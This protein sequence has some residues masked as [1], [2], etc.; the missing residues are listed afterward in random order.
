M[1]FISDGPFP[2]KHNQQFNNIDP[3]VLIDALAAIMK[4]EEKEL[5]KAANFA[6]IFIIEKMSNL[7]YERPWFAKLGAVIALKFLC[8]HMS[9]RWL[10][11]HLYTFLK[12][13]LFVSIF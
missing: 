11:Q 7:C 6:M 13:Y 3:L 8:E 2:L 10:Y 4:H 9:I 12:A 5:C 1:Y